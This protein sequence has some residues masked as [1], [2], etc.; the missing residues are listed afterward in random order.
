MA[1][2]PKSVLSESGEIQLAAELIRLGARLQLLEREVALS[3]D[4]L[5]QI[6]NELMGASPPKGLLP[7]SVD[8]FLTWQPNIHASLFASLHRQLLV[9]TSVSGIE[10]VIKAYRLYLE[11]MGPSKGDEPFLSFTRAWTLIR[12]LN[13][14]M[15]KIGI[16]NSCQG[17]FI[18]LPSERTRLVCGLC[19]VPNRAGKTKKTNPVGDSLDMSRC[20]NR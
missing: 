6:Y 8:W 9:N 17:S 12:F 14:K 1:K 13:N 15:L 11:Q 10:A 7:Y 4:R 16:C 18:V 2:K 20:P 19:R 3:R 5:I